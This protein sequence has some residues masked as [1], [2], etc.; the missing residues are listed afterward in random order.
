VAGFLVDDETWAIRY[1]EVL[2]RNWWPGKKVLVSPAWIQK[3][4]WTESKVYVGLWRD[5]IK[6]RRRSLSLRRS[7]VNTNT[8]S[9]LT[10]AAALLAAGR[11]TQGRPFVERRLGRNSRFVERRL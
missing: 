6:A 9:I 8:V 3:V 7:L 4:S 2:T 10:T 11:G 1:I 5:A